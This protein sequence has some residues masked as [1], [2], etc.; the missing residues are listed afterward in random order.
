MTLPL[1]WP[2]ALMAM[3]CAW[4]TAAAQYKMA[5][6]VGVLTCSVFESGRAEAGAGV[7]VQERDILC[8][9]RL[10]NGAEE[11]YT[12]KLQGVG[13]SGE[14]KGTL[15]WLVRAPPT[16]LPSPPGLLQQSYAADAKAPADEIPAL[17]GEVNSDIVLQSMA[18]KDEES[19]D[20]PEKSKPGDFI[21]LGVRLN[22]RSASG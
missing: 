19:T 8:S 5:I 4:N 7:E 15:L 14:Y 2:A 18:D 9:F 13:V 16:V 22:L 3:G 12:G 20:A 17:I 11:T 10:K 6:E 1:K 21:V